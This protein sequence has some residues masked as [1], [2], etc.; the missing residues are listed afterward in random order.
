MKR[1]VVGLRQALQPLWQPAVLLGAVMIALVWAGIV[2][3]L[4]V[5]QR[6]A[7]AAATQNAV[8]LARAF[9]QHVLRAIN[10]VDKSLLL[11]R[12]AYERSR[13]GFD[14]QRW[15]AN[16]RH[17]SDLTTQLA[18]I[19]PDGYLIATSAADAAGQVDL[20]DREHFRVHTGGNADILFI[21]RPVLGRI[22]G[23]WTVQLTRRMT[24]EDGGFG[25]VV[26]AALNPERLARL[27]DTL[28]LGPNGSVTLVGLDGFV[29]ARS[30][31]LPEL[32]GQSIG[33]TRLF[34]DHGTET[35]GTFWS[36]GRATSH[37]IKRLVAFRR[38]EGLPLMV[39]VGLADQDIFAAYREKR[40][41]GYAVASAA[42]AF[43]LGIVMLSGYHG[44][45]L[46]R[47]R[48][49]LTR[50][51]AMA[52][53]A[54]RNLE[55]TL[56]HMSHGIMMVDAEGRLVFVNERAARLLELPDDALSSRSTL[57]ELAGQYP[58]IKELG[59]DTAKPD[60]G[61]V[62]H[63]RARANGTMLEVRSIALPDGGMVHS[64]IDL[65]ERRRNDERMMQLAR[66]DALTGLANRAVLR[67]DLAKAAARMRRHG[68]KFAVFY[69]DLDQFK[70]VNDRLG[71]AAGD[72]LLQAVSK[73]LRETMRDTDTVAR[74]GGDEFAILQSAVVHQEDSARVAARI[75][76]ALKAPYDIDGNILTVGT[77]IGIALAPADGLE[78]DELMR[79]ADL[80]LYRAKAAGR[81]CF[82]FF[83]PGMDAEVRAR[84]TLEYDLQRAIEQNELRL[85]YQPIVA[86]ATQEIVGMEALV[87]WDHRR[88]G[89]LTSD[90]LMR[91]AEDVRMIV[92]LGEWLLNRACT[93]AAA[94]PAGVKLAVNLAPAQF[95]DRNLVDL[96]TEALAESGLPPR[97]LE[98]DVTET[99][100]H[101]QGTDNLAVLH[102]LRN[103]G[104]TMVL[105]DFGTGYA[106]LSY[107]RAFPF[108][109]IKIDRAFVREL[110][111]RPDCAAIV[112]TV[113]DLGKKLGMR[114]AAEDVDHAAQLELLRGFGCT[115]AQGE[116]FGMPK[117]A[118]EIG[119]MLGMKAAAVG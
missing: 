39:A 65:T 86:L 83:E 109:C 116:L 94:W 16:P 38:V 70:P 74:I 26:V 91:A 1:V 10:E 41:T 4:D 8:N 105:D 31:R 42:T 98:I 59:V 97:R 110:T 78:P 95:R 111:T 100:L 57:D 54:A 20:R 22:S 56:D 18:I 2:F 62:V 37:D 80:A 24:A 93:D 11:L 34:R 88:H 36:M 19:G 77:S 55:I 50:S 76:T 113:S 51:E 14:L 81:N 47:A 23:K 101:T 33:N 75:L 68:E 9:E 32:L 43:I 63:E 112:S 85:D 64:F 48:G 6:H 25:G 67:D 114:I 5:E 106:S 92:P 61:L 7:A 35:S 87:R 17:A 29:R 108:D 90:Q 60:G 30:G 27:Y 82:R 12:E 73:R 118:S 49:A 53:E 71:H 66:N 28:D 3:H 115:E 103:L 58:V 45:R 40:T 13:T 84:R 117:P 44:W 52:R 107:L 89:H 46:R 119:R 15:A 102:Q 72:A 104:I 96:V 21:S 99:V 69:L 79:N